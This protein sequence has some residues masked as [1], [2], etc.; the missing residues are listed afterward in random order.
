MEQQTMSDSTNP[1]TVPVFVLCG[2]LGTRLREETEYRPKPMVEIGDQPILWHIM[3]IYSRFGI[4]RFIL[5]L[6]YKGW[7]IKQYFLRYN[8]MH[9]DFSLVMDGHAAPEFLTPPVDEAWQAFFR[10]MGDDEVSV[11]Q[12]AAGPSWARADWPPQPNDDLTQALDGQWAQT[13]MRDAGKKIAA[14]AEA[15]ITIG[16]DTNLFCPDDPVTRAQMA[17][18]LVRAFLSES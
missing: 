8:E 11:K 14:I 4:R 1:A 6:G 10:Q 13:E 15:G 17:S 5:C 16:C 7:E 3:K 18:F 9:R 12:E 2:G